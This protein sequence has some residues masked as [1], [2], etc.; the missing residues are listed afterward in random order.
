MTL[1]Q[2]LTDV[3]CTDPGLA[4]LADPK[5][6]SLAELADLMRRFPDA[7]PMVSTMNAQQVRLAG[8]ALGITS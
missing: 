1:K 6:P 7:F 3:G 2:R 4:M 8:R 5:K